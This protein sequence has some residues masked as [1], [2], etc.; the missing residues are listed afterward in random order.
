M[1][2]NWMEISAA[3]YSKTDVQQTVAVLPTAAIEQH[4]PHLPVGT[5]SLIATGMLSEVAKSPPEV[6]RLRVL[7]VQ[8]VG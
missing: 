5:D 6:A 8:T 2:R 4:G 7:P 3:G 1:Y